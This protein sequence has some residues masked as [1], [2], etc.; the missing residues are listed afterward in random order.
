MIVVRSMHKE[1]RS[2][3]FLVA[4]Q[5]GGHAVF[6]DA[7]AP[8]EP[9]MGQ[10][11]QLD[12]GV[13]N[14]LLTHEHHDHTIH[15]IEIEERYDAIT[16]TPEQAPDG[17][18]VTCGR[19]VFR[20][21]ATPGHCTPHIA[22]LV[23]EQTA[24]ERNEYPTAIFTGDTLFK[25]TVGGTVNGGANGFA[26]LKD[27]I[28][29]RILSLPPETEIYPGHMEPTT[30]GAELANN[31]FVLAMQGKQPLANDPVTVA[32]QPASLL[33]EGPD[34]DGGTKAW[35]RF[36]D[37]RDAIVGGSMVSRA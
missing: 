36:D 1:Y 32:G 4:D 18:E 26:E 24:G 35:V 23:F 31:P 29:A 37:G 17:T 7:G 28:L 33:L 8:I 9:L 16:I 15:M 12:L 30:V 25:G 34:Y 5:P 22:W 11:E 27:S 20:A 19:L 6:I 2:N 13:T 3:S 14:V 21:L 10:I